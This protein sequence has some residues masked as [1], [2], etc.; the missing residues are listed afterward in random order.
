MAHPRIVGMDPYIEAQITPERMTST[1][2][3]RIVGMDPYIEAQAWRDCHAEVISGI[4]TSLTTRLAPKYIARIEEQIYIDAGY[5]DA[6]MR[7][8][9]IALERVR[10]GTSHTGGEVALA[11]KPIEPAAA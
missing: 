5:H 9:D 11:I 7:D 3:P 10:P 8:P 1:A 6:Q 4:R 2:I